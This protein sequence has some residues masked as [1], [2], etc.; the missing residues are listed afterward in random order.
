MNAIMLWFPVCTPTVIGE[1]T[2][3]MFLLK[4]SINGIKSRIDFPGC[5][6][7][8]AYMLDALFYSAVLYIFLS[9]VKIS[10]AQ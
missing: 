3:L 9:S 2:V 6:F 7:G 1:S 10:S 8:V 4:L 5:A